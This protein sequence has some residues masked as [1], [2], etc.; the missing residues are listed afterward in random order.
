MEHSDKVLKEGH[1]KAMSISIFEYNEVEEKEKIR[2]AEY[3]GGYEAGNAAGYRIGITESIQ[4]IVSDYLAEGFSDEKI[5]YKL[6]TI[7]HLSEKE[8]Q[9]CLAEQKNR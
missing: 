6:V 1:R 5:I 8:A 2:K 9:N 3:A 7:F 4:A